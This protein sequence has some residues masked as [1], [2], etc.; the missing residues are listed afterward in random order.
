M[1]IIF[2]FFF[3]TLYTTNWEEKRWIKIMDRIEDIDQDNHIIIHYKSM[4]I[5]NRSFPI[6]QVATGRCSYLTLL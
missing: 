6:L 2:F 3:Y 4:Q 1:Q 5:N